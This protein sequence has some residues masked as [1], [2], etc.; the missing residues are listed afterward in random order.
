LAIR[1]PAHKLKMTARNLFDILF[2]VAIALAALCIF[3]KSCGKNPAPE[4]EIESV[5]Q[6]R[7]HRIHTD[8]FV[9]RYD[10][11]VMI[12][13]KHDSAYKNH[14]AD[15]TI[16]YNALRATIQTLR[17]VKIDSIG[18]TISNLSIIDYNALIESGD[19]CDSMVQVMQSD[20]FTK[21]SIITLRTAQY[22]SVQ[23][24]NK[25]SEQTIS[26]LQALNEQD[27]KKLKR[28]EKL[29]RKIPL[30][31]GITVVVFVLT[32]IALK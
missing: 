28:S 14:I 12:K 3:A 1:L 15:L 2:G 18:Q 5:S 32:I 26:D 31:A 17:V 7:L 30:I 24:L 21:D 25:S 27:Q 20:L 8:A 29:N 23:A 10:S 9:A 22:E 16:K 4:K 19:I 6:L 11:L 13:Q